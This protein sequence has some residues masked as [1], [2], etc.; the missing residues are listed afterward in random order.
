MIRFSKLVRSRL[1][2]V[3]LACLLLI[4]VNL[5]VYNYLQMGKPPVWW[6][7]SQPPLGSKTMVERLDRRFTGELEQAAQ[8]GAGKEWK[9]EL[10]EE[11]ARSWVAIRLHTW[12][13]SRFPGSFLAA[14][15]TS[16]MRIDLHENGQ[17]LAGWQ[18]NWRNRSEIFWVDVLPKTTGDGQLRWMLELKGLG[19][20][21]IIDWEM[22]RM[23]D[24]SVG[25]SKAFRDLLDGNPVEVEVLS[26][27]NTRMVLDSL[28]IVDDG[29]VLGWKAEAAGS[30]QVHSKSTR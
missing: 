9:F 10:T 20:I 4:G 3:S 14:T 29:M 18:V 28:S 19:R 30:S 5:L 24:R 22:K 7:P 13:E 23:L 27:K 21:E 2:W 12:A 16:E 17:M 8:D 15:G 11:E 26:G 25:A 1:L 6:G